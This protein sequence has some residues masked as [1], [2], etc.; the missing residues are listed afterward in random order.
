MTVVAH[1]PIVIHFK[2][3]A[4]GFTAVDINLAIANVELIMLI[5]TDRTLV[6][7]YVFQCKP[8][9]F[10][11]LRYPYRTVIV[12]RPACNG[13]KRIQ[14][15]CNSIGIK[16][17][18]CYQ[19]L[20]GT[21]CLNGSLSERHVTVLIQAHQVF[22]R[23]SELLKQVIR[24]VGFQFYI[25]SILYIVGLLVGFAIEIYNTVLDL[26]RLS[27]QT[28]TALYIVFAPVGRTIVNASI[29]VRVVNNIAS[30]QIVYHFI[31]II[32]LLRV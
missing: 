16:A 8:D 17:Y 10:T 15:T 28:Y 9:G 21:K 19:I 24:Q 1:H 12:A 25:I 26:Q 2:R 5:N 4:V 22:L 11:L 7:G 18:A 31:V 23:Y 27:G 32:L 3:I 14:V 30:P 13:I 20:T 6:K 29:L